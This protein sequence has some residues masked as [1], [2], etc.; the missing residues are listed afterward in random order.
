MKIPE[1][2]EIKRMDLI[3]LG[4]YPRSGAEPGA[5]VRFVLDSNLVVSGDR[6]KPSMGSHQGRASLISSALVGLIRLLCSSLP[7][8]DILPA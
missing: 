3:S 5:V 7:D 4:F 1:I 6:H 2:V 8:W